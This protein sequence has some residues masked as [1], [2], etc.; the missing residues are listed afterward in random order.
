MHVLSSFSLC[1]IVEI[2][3]QGMVQPRVGWSFQLNYLYLINIYRHAQ[4]FVCQITLTLIKFTLE[5][6]Q[7]QR[8]FTLLNLYHIF[9]TAL[10]SLKDR[11]P[12]NKV[13]AVS[14]KLKW[15]FIL[16]SFLTIKTYLEKTF[17]N[18]KFW[19]TWNEIDI[20][21]YYLVP[22]AVKW[23]KWFCYFCWTAVFS[24]V[25]INW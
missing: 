21:S 13:Y 7:P 20:T 11:N 17:N 22:S 5:R 2:I 19:P 15:Y 12:H 10:L 25:L 18:S 1:F 6:N 8:Y 16:F 23:Q 3:A 9:S 24:T 4:R 14:P